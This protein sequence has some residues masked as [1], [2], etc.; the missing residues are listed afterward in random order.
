MSK[1]NSANVKKIKVYSEIVQA[2]VSVNMILISE[3]IEVFVKLLLQ[4]LFFYISIF[5]ATVNVYYF[6]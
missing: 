4:N 5:I 2:R 3:I 1:W 6:D